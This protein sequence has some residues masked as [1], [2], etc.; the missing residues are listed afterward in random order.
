MFPSKIT[1]KLNVRTFSEYAPGSLPKMVYVIPLG[2]VPGTFSRIFMF[3]IFPE[4]PAG[5]APG[6]FL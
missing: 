2:I 1:T 3:I 5:T 6:I 4:I